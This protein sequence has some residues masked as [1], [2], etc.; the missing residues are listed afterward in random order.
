VLLGNQCLHSLVSRGSTVLVDTFQISC[1]MNSLYNWVWHICY[2]LA[3]PGSPGVRD[4]CGAHRATASQLSK[5]TP[6]SSA[7]LHTVP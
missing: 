7:I 1:R 3:L 5:H 2:L 6:S 4:G